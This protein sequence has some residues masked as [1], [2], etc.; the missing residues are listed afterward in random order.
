VFADFNDSLRHYANDVLQID[1]FWF[2][3]TYNTAPKGL[4]APKEPLTGASV[5]PWRYNLNTGELSG[6]WH[7]ETAVC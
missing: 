3:D 6:L 5:V 1:E 7:R 4:P 2:V